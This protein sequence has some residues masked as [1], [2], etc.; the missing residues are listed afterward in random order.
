MSKKRH[1]DYSKIEGGGFIQIPKPIMNSIGY[2]KLSPQSVKLMLDLLIQYNGEN[3]GDLCAPFSL[4]KKKNW[5]SKGTLNRAI[6]ELLNSDFIEVS[7]MGG[8]NKCSLYAFTFIAVDECKGKLDIK[9]TRT[10]KSSWKKH[11][12]LQSIEQMQKDKF[13]KDEI[14]L[15]KNIF[16]LAKRSDEIN[17]SAPLKGQ[18]LSDCTH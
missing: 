8:R 4:M 12:P 11:E 2:S 5:K 18:C 16:D 10:P 15:I 9:S 6:K 1:Y 13:K 7:R 14:K 3:N 17:L